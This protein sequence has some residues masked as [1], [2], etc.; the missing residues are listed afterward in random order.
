VPR[1]SCRPFGTVRVL[2]STQAA[3]QATQADATAPGVDGVT[4][5]ERPRPITRWLGV[6]LPGIA[7]GVAVAAAG[8]FLAA[9]ATETLGGMQADLIR[10]VGRLPAPARIAA[11]GLAQVAA[12]VAPVVVAVGAL[13]TRRLRMLAGLVVG[14]ALA[15][16]TMSLLAHLVIDEAQ[17]ASWQAVVERESWVT[18]RAFPTSAY[19]AGAVAAVVVLVRWLGRR[20]AAPLWWAVAVLAVVRVVS[21]TN[22]PLDLLVALGMGFAGGSAALVA[23]GSPDL[24]PRGAAVVEAL[25]RNGMAVTRLVEQDHE[26]GVSH[27]FLATTGARTL[28]VDVRSDSDRDRDAVAHLYARARTRTAREDELFV[29]VGQA[30]ERAAFV[31]LWLDHLGVPAATPRAVARLGAD[32]ALIARDAVAGTTLTDQGEDVDQAALEAAWRVVAALHRGR[33]AHGQLT[34]D[35]FVVEDEPAGARPEGDDG[36]GRP[37]GPG[38]PAV[39]AR[40]LQAATL[41]APDALIQVD[42]ATF[43]VATTLLVGAERAVRACRAGLGDD[44]LRAALPYLQ[45]PALPLRLRLR[46]RGAEKVVSGLRDEARAAI[47][48]DEVELVRLVRVQK[49]T[50]IGLVGG[51]LA[52]VVLLPQVTTL[53]AAAQAAGEADW[54]WLLPAVVTTALGYVAATVTLRAAT[55]LRPPFGLSYLTQL[56]AA[57][58]N[59]VTPNGIGGLGTNIRFLQR[60]GYDTTEAAT[61][62]ALVSLNGAVAGAVLIAVF[63]TWAGQSSAAFP[64]PSD[65]VLLVAAAAVLGAV[66]LV[67]AVPALRRLVGERLGPIMRTVRSSVT[68]LAA[69]PRRAATMLTASVVNSLMQLAGLLFVLH[70]FGV[71]VGIP[72]AGAV[73]FGGRALAG[74]AP[75]PGGLGAVE[76]ALIGGL[77]GAGVDAAVATPAVLVFRLV[78]NWA[79]IVP[80]WFAL[81]TLRARHAL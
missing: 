80:G 49:S 16:G 61:V 48:S 1:T 9:V 13:A 12:V 77:T 20:W 3:D 31:G 43:L 27:A 62:M 50:V 64:W 65:S 81:R 79:V 76:A 52:L 54:P 23:V 42:R 28:A 32:A 33:V 14:A 8:A 59:R 70:A 72:V 63:L 41:D 44:G 40:R 78:T 67:V 11:I 74:A 56:A 25:R 36:G 39:W 2:T 75:T 58:L 37:D 55:P 51:L 71:S 15:A 5:E 19:L 57:T 69:D 45:V 24:S 10:A 35:A 6:D 47:G 46:L 34:T 17:P 29:P 21:G 60:S 73:L 68:E 38:G 53:S 30:A 22:L 66:G 4:I 26:P 18:G 7:A